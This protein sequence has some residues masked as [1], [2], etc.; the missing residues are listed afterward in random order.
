MRRWAVESH[1]VRRVWQPLFVLILLFGC[2]REKEA[3][4]PSRSVAQAAAAETPSTPS[5]GDW[6]LNHSLSDP[7]KLNPLTS[8]D[9]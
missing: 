3:V 8:S 7:E 1:M 9:A 4:A 2:G 6:L 5:T